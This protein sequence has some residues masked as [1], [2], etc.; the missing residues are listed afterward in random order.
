MEKWAAES[1]VFNEWKGRGINILKG[2]G[3]IVE[4]LEEAQVGRPACQTACCCTIGAKARTINRYGLRH[5]L[6]ISRT[7]S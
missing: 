2:T 6:V 7:T 4:E 3:T 1:F 5:Q